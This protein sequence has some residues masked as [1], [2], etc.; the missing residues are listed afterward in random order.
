[1]KNKSGIF[2]YIL[3]VAV[4]LFA[5]ASLF[6]CGDEC[7]EHEWGVWLVNVHPNWTDYGYLYRNCSNCYTGQTYDLPPLSSS[8]YTENVIKEATCTEMGVS[9]F[10][11]GEVLENAPASLTV[12]TPTVP[13][14]LSVFAQHDATRHEVSCS[15]CEGY[16]YEDHKFIEEV[17]LQP[18]C[19]SKGKANVSCSSCGYTEDDRDI[20]MLAHDYVALEALEATC[21]AA[22]HTAGRVCSVCGGWDESVSAIPIS[23][24]LYESGICK[25][26]PTKQPVKVT[27]VY[28]E[29]DSEEKNCLYGD[30]FEVR[31]E[32]STAN[33][34]FLGWFT[35]EGVKFT[36]DTTLT[37][38]VTLFAKWDTAIFINTKEDFLK[39][40]EDPTASYY[41]RADI[42]MK[43]E[44]L[45]P[46]ENFSGIIDGYC[47]DEDRNYIIKNFVMSADGD[48]GYFGIFATNSGTVKNV[49]FKDFTFSGN[50]TCNDGGAIGG[51]AGVNKGTLSGVVV[52][53]FKF[54]SSFYRDGLGGNTFSL[55]LLTGRN[56]GRI[57]QCDITGE[58]G[59]YVEDYT[60]REWYSETG[61]GRVRKIGGAVGDNFGKISETYVSAKMDVQTLAHNGGYGY[62]YVVISSYYGGFVGHNRDSGEIKNSY[63]NIDL[64][65]RS[66]G[67]HG[68]SYDT[69]NFGGFVGRSDNTSKISECFAKGS[70][71]GNAHT[72]NRI[73][74]FAGLNTATAS[75]SSAYAEVDVT[76]NAGS[77]IQAGGFVGANSALIQN[78][79][80]SGSLSAFVGATLGGFIGYNDKGGTVTKAYTTAN[81]TATSGT[82]NIFVGTNSGIISKSY[83]TDDIIFKP[84]TSTV[85]SLSL[86]TEIIDIAFNR[87]ISE[88][89][90]LENLYWD[91]EGWYVGSDN[92]PFLNWEFEKLHDYTAKTIAPTCTEAGFTV[93]ECKVCGSIFI[94]DVIAPLGHNNIDE[95]EPDKWTEPTH[96]ESGTH[97][98]VCVH[99]EYGISHVYTVTL[100]PLG[101][102]KNAD[103]S[104]SDLILEGGKYYH[105]CSCSTEESEVLVEV[106][107]SML[108]HTPENSPYIAPACGAYNE[109]T[110]EWEGS[111]AGKSA[112][113][114]CSDCGYII[115]GCLTIEPH[116][117]IEGDKEKHT[118]ATCK[119]EGI[120][121]E[122][123]SSCGF[124]RNRV[125]DKLEHIYT[126]GVLTCTVCNEERHKIDQSFVAIS[127]VSDLKNMIPNGNYYLTQNIDLENLPFTPLF[128]EDDPFVGIFLGNGY[129]IKNLVL[130]AE[131]GE[132]YLGGIFAAV[133]A[134]GEVLGL[135]VENATVA[136]SNVN[137]LKLGLIA[138]INKGE[139][140]LCTVKGEINVVLNTAVVSKTVGTMATS[141]DYVY[142]TVAAENA[143]SGEINSCS[144]SGNLNVSVIV[145]TNLSATGVSEYFS[146]LINNTKIENR[147]DIAFGGAVGVNRGSVTSSALTGGLIFN[148]MVESKVG[149]VNRGRTFTYLDLSA[150]GFCGINTGNIQDCKSKEIRPIFHEKTENSLV[151]DNSVSVLGVILKQEYIEVV[152][153]SVFV[154]TYSGLIGQS[155]ASGTVEGLTVVTA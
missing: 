87:L 105:K 90:L 99:E 23:A 100:A 32:N 60:A 116:T 44:K 28:G 27:Y 129:S 102:D 125:V 147:S 97:R 70:M 61:Y 25:W 89:F 62:V 111:T 153:R 54:A 120:Y 8:W 21:K 67:S 10:V 74:G 143:A 92:N 46:V 52:D 109:E 37:S 140:S 26:C 48:V 119:T 108:T 103:I 45:A 137:S 68:R 36:A 96:T 75:I 80:S 104:C 47:A 152:E 53:N 9:E 73:G 95:Y 7:T 144:V 71:T 81:L 142:G 134:S 121:N 128:S 17:T 40:A 20:D 98:Y 107:R 141:F 33:K 2:K 1:M 4:L 110:C 145:S 112:G 34:I 41:L 12:N 43:G 78:S 132:E 31:E 106:D 154:D 139:I 146:Q 22:G 13:H 148:V 65:L 42:D 122:V 49:T 150:G 79:Y 151:S 59:L 118:E 130:K 136:V 64:V 123:C 57:E 66:G 124:E 149:G 114:V 5:L 38:D 35:E 6:S 24:H 69:T 91:L 14:D 131:D 58:I 56:E 126:G 76:V 19:T 86:T 77:D 94:T 63:A 39:I 84:G 82:A 55:G 16:K 85:G 135:T 18:T 113:R 30:K 117:F 88:E 133:G 29:N 50:V 83:Q 15:V 101:H 11:F 115:A 127:S 155:T 138:G 93:C 51:V 3:L 72:G